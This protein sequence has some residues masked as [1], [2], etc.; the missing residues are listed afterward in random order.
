[1]SPVQPVTAVYE[2][3]RTLLVGSYVPVVLNVQTGPVL[4]GGK[5]MTNA[6]LV[7]FDDV[8]VSETST[9][10]AWLV[11]LTLTAPP[12]FAWCCASVAFAW[13]VPPC[14]SCMVPT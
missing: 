14:V 2:P 3:L 7:E 1:V 13:P 8:I 11:S 5:S 6:P 4:A 12:A 10:R 9:V